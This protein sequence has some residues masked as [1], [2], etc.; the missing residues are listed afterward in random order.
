MH[1]Y[2]LVKKGTNEVNLLAGRQKHTSEPVI[3][4]SGKLG[5]LYEMLLYDP[6]FFHFLAQK[7]VCCLTFLEVFY[8]AKQDSTFNKMFKVKETLEFTY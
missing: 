5:E 2:F 1:T 8:L 6:E 4:E 3:S 7:R